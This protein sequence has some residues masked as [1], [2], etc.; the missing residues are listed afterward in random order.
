[1]PG[2]EVIVVLLIVVVVVS[3]W[4]YEVSV[5]GLHNNAAFGTKTE[6]N[7]SKGFDLLV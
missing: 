1:M 4:Q 5:L 6:N 7:S 2:V 3:C